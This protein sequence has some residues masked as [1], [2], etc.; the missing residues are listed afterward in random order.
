MK[1]FAG[2]AALVLAVPGLAHAAGNV[3]GTYALRLDE[4]CQ[5]VENEIFKPSTQIQTI[6]EGNFTR[7]IG[8][9][10]FTPTT[11]GGTSGTVSANFTQGKGTLTILGL[12]GPPPQP[13]VPDVQMGSTTKTGTYSVT[14]P[15]GTKP[16]TFKITFKGDTLNTFTAY[17]SQLSG[18]AY[19]H[20]DFLNTE[21]N[22]DGEAPSCVQSGTLQK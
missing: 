21:S 12:P 14:I 6:D 4:I 7:T 1:L 8:L 19:A 18:A 22:D 5:S 17:F 15:A 11:A 20:V 10:T 3:S 2:L 16:G 9:I 13:H